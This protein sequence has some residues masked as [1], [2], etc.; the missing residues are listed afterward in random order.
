M[1]VGLSLRIEKFI[2]FGEK[3]LN[4]SMPTIICNKCN[5]EKDLTSVNFKP[6]KRT[7]LGFD[8][9]CRKCRGKRQSQIR[10]ENPERFKLIDEKARET[11]RYKKYQEE[12]QKNNAEKL[13][14]G[15]KDRYYKNKEP[16]LKRSKDQKIRLG[17][18][19]KEYQKEYR[20]KNRKELSAKYLHKLKTDP[21]T[22]LRH[23]LRC[24]FRKLIKGYHKQN[25]VLTYIG[26]DIEFLKNYLSSKFKEGMT[27]ENHGTVWHIDHIIPCVSF[28][29]NCEEDLKKCWHYTNLQPLY[30][31]ENLIKGNKI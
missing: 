14:E 25:S 7:I 17:I 6:E 11:T 10:K 22:K 21:N 19:Y 28:D 16:Y 23:T 30:A 3:I 27:W 18:S 1:N 15:C 4:N 13:K 31:L 8:S 26:C 20:K 2:N 24:R 12:Y 5:I 29:F 9:T